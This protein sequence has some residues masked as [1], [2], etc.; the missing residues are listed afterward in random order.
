PIFG[1]SLQSS[2][3]FDSASEDITSAQRSSTE[4]LRS[5]ASQPAPAPAP[6]RAP[7]QATPVRSVPAANRKS[8]T[9]HFPASS[10][11]K[12]KTAAPRTQGGETSGNI[13]TPTRRRRHKRPNT[14]V[15]SPCVEDL[16]QISAL[17]EPRNV[18]TA[19]KNITLG[20]PITSSNDDYT[21]GV[22]DLQPSTG[23]LLSSE[24][25]NIA[26]GSRASSSSDEI[27]RDLNTS[28]KSSTSS[29][30][31]RSSLKSDTTKQ[32]IGSDIKKRSP[33]PEGKREG[34][35]GIPWR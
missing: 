10:G 11:S 21:N 8:M 6:A 9:P 18:Q 1:E 2:S 15:T 34:W 26:L 5:I 32:F 27:T 35:F 33:V 13:D 23:R 29:K 16:Q 22:G 31:S 24:E 17:L 4:P 28:Q 12:W 25:P 7:L 14:T 30:A 3:R 20:S 19:V